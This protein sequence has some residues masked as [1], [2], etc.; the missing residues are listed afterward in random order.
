VR[1]TAASLGQRWLRGNDDVPTDLR[2]VAAHVALQDGDTALFDLAYK[3]FSESSDPIERDRLLGALS[4]VTDARSAR[5]LALTFDPVLH[6]NEVTVP[7][8]IQFYDER[9][10]AAA[11]QFMQDHLDALI[12]KLSRERAGNLPWFAVPMCTTQTADQLQALFA[13][14]IEQLIGGPRSLAGATEALR[15]CA[16]EAAAQ[17][18]S[19]RAYFSGHH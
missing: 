6:Q 4:S 13:P 14:R 11:Y 15:L 18:Q 10:R 9:T 17:Q 19:A 1:K 7:L 8:R 5:A 16:A 2:S 3:R 12:E